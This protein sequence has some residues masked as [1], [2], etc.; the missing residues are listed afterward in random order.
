MISISRLMWTMSS[1]SLILSLRMDFI[2]TYKVRKWNVTQRTKQMQISHCWGGMENKYRCCLL[3]KLATTTTELHRD[4]PCLS[5][6]N[7]PGFGS[8]S[9]LSNG[10]LTRHNSFI[11]GVLILWG[12]RGDKG[13]WL[14][15]ANYDHGRWNSK[16]VVHCEAVVMTLKQ[17]KIT[18]W[19]PQ[20]QFRP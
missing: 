15:Q 5:F 9:S 10:C 8:S 2:A 3:A 13:R 7:S 17:T 1:S 12:K 14:L 18:V 20:S 6:I 19:P 16:H 11:L 4:P